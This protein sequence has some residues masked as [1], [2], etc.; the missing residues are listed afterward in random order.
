MTNDDTEGYD[1]RPATLAHSLRVGTLMG[2]VITELVGRST[3]HDLSKTQ[4][5]EVEAFDRLTPRLGARY[6]SPEYNAALA[7]LGPALDHHYEVNRHHPEFVDRNIEWR[8]VVG[9]EGHYEVSSL[10]DVR[11]VDRTVSRTGPTGDVFKPGQVRKAQVTPKGYLRLALVRDGA[12]RNHMVH[13][14]VAE[15]FIPNPDGKPEVNH[16]DGNKT[17][18][19][20]TNLEW[21]TPSENQIHAYE[22]GLKESSVKYVVHCPELDLTT[23]GTQAMEHKLKEFGYERAAA[24]GVWAAMDRGGK[25][26]DLTFEGTVLAEYR[27]SQV[28]GMTLTDLVE[29][30]ADW[31][32]AGERTEGGSLEA[33]LRINQERFGMND[34][35]VRILRNTAEH[36]GWLDRGD[37]GA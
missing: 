30:L 34:Q 4:P 12:Q 10:G 19:A 6:G 15:A 16:R 21:S 36:F 27:R 3:A 17:N 9:Y 14:V 37:G 25:H 23:F 20:V 33:S 1:S 7:E 32:A 11:S 13:R 18:N 2:D 26:L 24:S 35:L 22:T 8:S 28:S 29:M 31:K 5:P